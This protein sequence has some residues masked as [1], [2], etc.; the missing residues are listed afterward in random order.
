MPT[1]N[2]RGL[3][4]QGCLT[5]SRRDQRGENNREAL[6]GRP[7]D[8][9]G[10]L[11]LGDDELLSKK[12]VLGDQFNATANEIRGQ[13]GN[14]SK[15]VDHGVESYTVGADDICSQDDPSRAPSSHPSSAASL[16]CPR[17][18]DS[19][20]ATSAAQRSRRRRTLDSPARRS[21]RTRRSRD[22][23]LP[24]VRFDMRS[25]SSRW[26]APRAGRTSIA[27]MIGA[28]DRDRF[29]ASTPRDRVLA[30]D[31]SANSSRCVSSVRQQAN[32]NR[33]DRPSS[34]GAL[35]IP[36]TH[37]TDGDRGQRSGGALALLD[38]DGPLDVHRGEPGDA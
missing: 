28:A 37:V 27:A 14:E 20:A 1:K 23:L 11:P 2:G 32:V 4:E 34:P 15:K 24:A 3:D 29:V 31:K 19:I 6:P 38:H 8:A 17:S 22:G 26:H 21:E 18:A 12:R 10:K 33:L 30:N 9:P 35:R 7:P 36:T 5:P 16:P 25:S 13:S